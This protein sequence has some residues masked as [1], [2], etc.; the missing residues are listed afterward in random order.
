MKLVPLCFRLSAKT[1]L[2]F[3]HF[4]LQIEPTSL[5]FD[6]VWGRENAERRE[7]PLKVSPAFTK[8]AE[9]KGRALGRASQSAKSLIEIKIR[10]GMENPIKGFSIKPSGFHNAIP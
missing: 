7:S 5:G 4:P 10:K 2:H 3:L 8:A 6:L 9:S 1:A